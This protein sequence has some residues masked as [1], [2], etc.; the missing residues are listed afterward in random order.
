MKGYYGAKVAAPVFKEIAH[1][2]YTSKPSSVQMVTDSVVSKTVDKDY[3]K[4][5]AVVSKYKTIMP[6]VI[7]MS[8]MDAISLL[9]NMG[10][11]VS[12][13]GMG[14]VIEQ[15]IERGVKIKKGTTIHLKLS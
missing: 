8:G 10:L 5:F 7:G 1:K 11:K 2:I 14:K 12:F 13:S 6:K 4:Y 9:E 15:S 3:N